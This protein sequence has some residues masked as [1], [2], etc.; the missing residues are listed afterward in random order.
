LIEALTL[1]ESNIETQAVVSIVRADTDTQRSVAIEMLRMHHRYLLCVY[2]SLYQLGEMAGI[3]EE[4]NPGSSSVFVW[5]DQELATAE[6]SQPHR[7]RGIALL[8][9]GS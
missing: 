1:A 3:E 6:A 7:P 2:V 8:C 4:T 9:G 5:L